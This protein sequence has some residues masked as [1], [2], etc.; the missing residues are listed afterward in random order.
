[1]SLTGTQPAPTQETDLR[2]VI[3]H[4]VHDLR[5]PLGG[6]ESL[7]YYFELALEDCDDELREQCGRLRQLVAQAS[8]MLEDAA[9]AAQAPAKAEPLLDLNQVVTAVGEHMAGHEE[10]PL[11]LSLAAARPRV[12]AAADSVRRWLTH[13][14]AYFQDV[15]QGEPMPLVETESER[16]GVWLRVRSEVGVRDCLRALDPPGS[17][18]GLRRLA[19]LTGGEF[20]C[21]A[22]EGIVT[23]GLWLPVAN[24]AFDEVGVVGG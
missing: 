8:W 23:V 17:A 21:H 16:E 10:R 15:A 19:S 2:E 7:A 3:R 13:A 6:I 5:Q 1:M 9:L 4:L 20:H 11:R 22:D 24:D 12:R 18:G 14:L